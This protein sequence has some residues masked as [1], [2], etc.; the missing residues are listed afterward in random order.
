MSGTDL[1]RWSGVASMLFGVLVA[2]SAFQ[3]LAGGDP[4][5]AAWLAFTGVTF[6]LIGF[7][8]IYVLFVERTGVLGS[9]AFVVAMIG[10]ALSLGQLYG[11]TFNE[12]RTGPLGPLFPLGYGPFL[13]GLLLFD[14]VIIWTRV[15]P[16]PAPALLVLGAA[17]NA[18]GFATVEIRLLGVVVFGVG[19]VWLGAAI[20]A[21][22]RTR[23]VLAEAVA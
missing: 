21:G 1:V 16:R 3:R 12:P 15:L 6:G 7:V 9:V 4:I 19:F 22:I 8:G 20:W 18:A 11:L 17:M 2:A 14:A 5:L 10:F 13:F 23:N